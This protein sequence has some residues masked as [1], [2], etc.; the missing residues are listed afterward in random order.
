MI[1][2]ST[3]RRLTAEDSAFRD[4]VS[5]GAAS[6]AVAFEAV[7]SKGAVSEAAMSEAA[8]SEAAM[9]E[10]VASEGAASKDTDPAD[11]ACADTACSGAGADKVCAGVTLAA[12]DVAVSGTFF[13]VPT[14]SATPVAVVVRGWWPGVTR[15]E[16]RRTVTRAAVVTTVRVATVQASHG[17]HSGVRRRR[18]KD[19]AP[20]RAMPNGRVQLHAREWRCASYSRTPPMPVSA[21]TAGVRAV[22]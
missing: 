10:A 15:A 3:V 22:V 2:A 21:A 12:A 16:V 19:H 14:S 11:T 17:C 20:V 1:T 7:A 5:E 18:P 9:S 8:V 13:G 6:E 4:A